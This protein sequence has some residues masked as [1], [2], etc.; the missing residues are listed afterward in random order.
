MPVLIVVA[1]ANGA[2]IAPEPPRYGVVLQ[3][4]D[5]T[6]PNFVIKVLTEV[7]RSDNATNLM[8]EA[9]NQGSAI[10]FRNTKDV[11]HTLVGKA[12]SMIEAAE[13]GT[14]FSTLVEKCE[15]TFTGIM[16]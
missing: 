14:H 7:F 11:C 10:V 3:N 4:D 9:H 2:A 1:P 6:F 16:L 5:T 12:N 15:L 13:P 8:K